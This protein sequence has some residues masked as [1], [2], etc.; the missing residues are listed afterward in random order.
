M[1]VLYQCFCWRDH[2][3]LL[4]DL[5]HVERST[6]RMW[7]ILDTDCRLDRSHRSGTTHSRG[8]L[9]LDVECES[10]AD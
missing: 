9:G 6:H 1:H 5:D 8:V 10:A 2:I 7:Q 3:D 4:K